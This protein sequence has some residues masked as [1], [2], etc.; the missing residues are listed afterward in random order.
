MRRV[1]ALAAWAYPV[2]LLLTWTLSLEQLLTGLV[3]AVAVG[4]A[5]APLG[6]V[7]RPWRLL[8]PRRLLAV[9]RL[10]GATLVRIVVANVDLA[11]RIWSPG[12]PLRSG[13]LVVPTTQRTDG[14][15]AATG[16]ITSLIVGNQIVDVDRARHQ[17]QYHAV[18]LPHGNRQH[19]EDDVNAPIERLIAP[20]A[21]R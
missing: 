8:A 21:G 11:R 14:G 7:A 5:F 9:A 13:M 15:L 18:E 10:I 1:V 16:L 19:P 17:L 20:L 3:V 12:L 6:E 4:L 2:W